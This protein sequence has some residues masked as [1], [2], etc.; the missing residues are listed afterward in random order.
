MPVTATH[1]L[2]NISTATA[3][4]YTTASI[5]VP[6]NR[7]VLAWIQSGGSA[8]NSAAGPPTL[9]GAGL[10]WTQVATVAFSTIAAPATRLTLF[11]ATSGASSSSGALTITVPT[12]QVYGGWSVAAFDPPYGI[13]QFATNRVDAVGTIT[14]SLPAAPVAGNATAG[15]QGNNNATGGIIRPTGG[16]STVLGE[17]RGGNRCI[18][19]HWY[20]SAVQNDS[21][22]VSVFGTST[23]WG[24]ITVEVAAAPL[25]VPA[26][27]TIQSQA[28][29]PPLQSAG[30]S[31][32][33][34]GP[35]WAGIAAE[36]GAVT[37]V[38]Q[39]RRR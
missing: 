10:T 26:I 19:S 32:A 27:R 24:G 2:T 17:V 12:T 38:S 3:T 18:H 9:A 6:A 16:V 11:T 20:P 21:V 28:A 25:V 33:V 15:G 31:V 30:V 34:A 29:D 13:V 37:P 35:A 5:T 14:V 23:Y 39:R 8:A 36:V 4:V 1:L 7:L 22:G